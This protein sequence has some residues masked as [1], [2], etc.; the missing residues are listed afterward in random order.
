MPFL[1]ALVAVPAS[2]DPLLPPGGDAGIP[3]CA[4]SVAGALPFLPPGLVDPGLVPRGVVN[5]TN[6]VPG[7]YPEVVVLVAVAYGAPFCSGTLIDPSWVLT[8]A[9]CVFGFESAFANGD[10][11]VV[12][13]ANVFAPDD[14][15]NL[16]GVFAAEGIA[17]PV[18]SGAADGVHDVGLVR[19]ATPITSITPAVLND[20]PFGFGNIGDELTFVGYGAVD[21]DQ[22]GSGRRRYA[23]MPLLDVDSTVLWAFD[24]S[25]PHQNLCNGDSGGA[26]FENTPTGRELAGVN[27]VVFALQ[28]GDQPCDDGGT[29][30][31]RVDIHIP[32]IQEHAPDVL[33]EGPDVPIDTGTPGGGT[34]TGTEDVQVEAPDWG[35]PHR[36]TEDQYPKVL[37]CDVAGGAFSLPGWLAAL[38]LTP[39]RRRPYAFPPR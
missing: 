19:L 39:R 30:A 31:A 15:P 23:D 35:E 16:A 37:G 25:D 13:D 33:L 14:P 11:A 29:G 10:I 28:A 6:A 22:S 36:P 26:A 38:W 2:A 5:G 21:D 20:E 3:G 32:W 34:D 1:L 24:D 27:S 12:I 18:D 17:N 4:G 8:A 7:E 9:H